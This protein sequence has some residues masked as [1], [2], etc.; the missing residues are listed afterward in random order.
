MQLQIYRVKLF[1]S[2][3]SE[4]IQFTFFC[5]VSFISFQFVCRFFL[6]LSNYLNHFMILTLK[7]VAILM[8]I[9][10]YHA[11][12]LNIIQMLKPYLDP[13]EVMLFFYIYMKK[14]KRMDNY[15]SKNQ[16]N[17]VFIIIGTKFAN[18]Q[19]S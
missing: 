8:S 16:L 3:Q 7:I 4:L 5:N 2:H 13:L 14:E 11:S 19:Y 12:M 9:R 6:T 17:S 10:F 15:I 1:Y 18:F